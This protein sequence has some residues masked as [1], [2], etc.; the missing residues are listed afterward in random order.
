MLPPWDRKAKLVPM[1]LS[2]A[3]SPKTSEYLSIY[4]IT[5]PAGTSLKPRLVAEEIVL[6]EIRILQRLP[7]L[8]TRVSSFGS[9]LRDCSRL[10]VNMDARSSGFFLQREPDVSNQDTNDL[11]SLRRLRRLRM[12]Q[13][14]NVSG[15]F[16]Y[17]L[18][19]R[20]VN[21]KRWIPQ[22]FFV[23]LPKL[24]YPLELLFPIPLKVARNQPVRR[25]HRLVPPL[26]EASLVVRLLDPVLP[27][28][29]QVLC[30]PL[31]L[32]NG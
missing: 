28:A 5:L 12:P 8:L 29:P 32:F 20:W 27:L 22:S 16:S 24:L 23:L 15:Q 4:G 7:F 9:A 14:R 30:S 11:L 3:A 19:I 26:S 18:K 13:A 21:S 6:I 17:T 31:Q 2:E 25:I 10:P 1:L